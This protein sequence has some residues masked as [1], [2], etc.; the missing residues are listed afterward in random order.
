MENPPK[1]FFRLSPGKEVRLKGAYIIKCDDVVKDDSTGEIIELRCSY[2]PE[3]KSGTSGSARKVKGTI[4]WVSASHAVPIKVRLYD[5]LFVE[6][7]NGE[8]QVNKD[9]L[10]ELDSFGEPVVAEAEPGARF[11]FLRQGY[12][13]VDTKDSRPGH[14]VF[15]RIV[16]LKS[17]YKPEK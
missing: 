8:L 4:H 5:Q 7:E 14:L 16:S 10:T 2:D 11:Q 6:D 13:C 9:S 1:K 12:F 17:S 3:T 15:N